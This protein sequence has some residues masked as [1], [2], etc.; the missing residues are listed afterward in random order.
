MRE[1]KSSLAWGRCPD[2]GAAVEVQIRKPLPGRILPHGCP[3]RVR[4]P[5]V[6]GRRASRVDVPV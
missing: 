4:I 6:S 3:A 5:G 1:K 2:C